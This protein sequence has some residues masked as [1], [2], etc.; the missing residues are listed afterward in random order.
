[1]VTHPAGASAKD[2]FQETTPHPHLDLTVTRHERCSI[3]LSS[4]PALSPSSEKLTSLDATHPCSYTRA[5]R[6]VGCDMSVSRDSRPEY[7]RITRGLPHATLDSRAQIQQIKLPDDAGGPQE[8]VQY[9]TFDDLPGVEVLAA[10]QSQRLWREFHT[11]YDICIL[12]DTVKNRSVEATIRY[13]GRSHEV[14]CGSTFVVEPGEVHVT[15]RLVAPADFF[16][17]QMDPCLISSMASQL[18]LPGTPHFRGTLSYVPEIRAAFEGF[19]RSLRLDETPLERQTRLSAC[20]RVLQEHLAETTPRALLGPP[21]PSVRR[22]REYLHEHF[23]EPVRLDDLVTVTG[24]SRFQL[25]RSF[26]RAYGLPP[27]AYQ[28][29][30]R[31]S[32]VREALARGLPPADIEAGFADQS[33]MG[34][35]FR[36]VFGI[37]PA[38]YRAAVWGSGRTTSY[39]L[40]H[41]STREP[42]IASDERLSRSDPSSQHPSNSRM[43]G[44]CALEP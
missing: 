23:V 32:A 15:Q 18:G 5:A 31:V 41:P 2:T 29:R 44:S 28:I 38:R 1:V 7:D 14:Q 33:H 20:I 3:L 42:S 36:R 12:P 34:R 26:T 8:R 9:A 25:V 16:V 24:L 6:R 17:V 11:T 22:A 39:R 13:R 27:H 21:H 43:G 4:A 10:S 19:H 35:H 40:D 30:L 37:S